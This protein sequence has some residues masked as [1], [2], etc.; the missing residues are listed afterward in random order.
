MNTMGTPRPESSPDDRGPAARALVV[1]RRLDG[2]RLV[3]SI[4]GEA[5]VGSVLELRDGLRRALALAHDEVSVDLRGLTFC[6]L[7]GLDALN[8]FVREATD[9][10]LRTSIHGMSPVLTWLN[11]TFPPDGGAPTVRDRSTA[12]GTGPAPP[13]P[14]PDSP[15]DGADAEALHPTGAPR[16][17]PV[18]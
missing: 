13:A 9:R 1:A 15:D 2:P 17:W 6:D 10:G 16:P 18:R 3:L 11:E 14:G 4:F 5:D 8:S 12:S 7:A